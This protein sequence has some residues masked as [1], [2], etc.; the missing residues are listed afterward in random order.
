MRDGTACF[1]KAAD[2][3]DSELA[4]PSLLPGWSRRHVIAHVAANAVAL[5]NLVHWAATGERTPMYASP[6]DRTSDI[7]RGS[8]LP[9]A[10]LRGWLQRSAEELEQAMARLSEDQWRAEVVTHSG[11]TVPATTIAWM[12][13]REVFIHTVD[14]ATGVTFADLPTDFL[15]ALCEDIVGMRSTAAAGPALLLEITSDPALRW[16]VAG[17]EGTRA[18]VTGSLPELAAYLS[19]RPHRLGPVPALPPWL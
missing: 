2:L 10:V 6:E 7:A 9:T 12:R 1:L 17:I 18:T 4:L 16:E 13:A 8:A 15:V 14:L 11:R 5:G 3:D 19:G